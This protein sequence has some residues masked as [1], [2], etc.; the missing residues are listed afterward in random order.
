[1]EE[2][3]GEWVRRKITQKDEGETPAQKT[4]AR[5]K[6]TETMDSRPRINKE[7]VEPLPTARSTERKSPQDKQVETVRR[8]PQAERPEQT[9]GRADAPAQFAKKEE[10]SQRNSRPLQTPAA[11]SGGNVAGKQPQKDF[12]SKNFQGPR[13][14]AKPTKG[15]PKKKGRKSEFRQEVLPEMIKIEEKVSVRDLAAKLLK[16]PADLVKKLM[17]LGMNVSLNN[18][19]DYA[20]AELIALDYNVRVEKEKSLEE[21]ILDTIPDD[22]K[23]MLPRPPVVTVMG[24]VDHGKTSL[25]D[26]IRQ[27]NVVAKEAGGITQH[28]GAYQVTFRNEKITF[29]DT[30]GHEAFTA[31]RARGAKSTDIAILVVAA[32]DG[33]MPQTIEAINHAKAAD[34]P[35]IIAVNKMDKE[36]ANP[37]RVKQQLTEHQLIPEEWGGDSIFVPVSAKTREGIELLLEM[38]L[39]LSEMKELKAESDRPAE[40]LVIEGELDRGRGP[41]ASILV[42][43]GTLRIGDS[44]ICGTTFG[45]VRAMVDDVGKR[46]SKAGPSTPVEVLG[47]AD[48]PM[49]GDP[50]RVV[51]EKVARQVS[52]IRLGEK[53]REEQSKTS[54]VTLDDFFKQIQEGEV[55]ELNLIVKGDVQGSIEALNQSLDRLS[56]DEVKVNVIHTGVGAVTESDVMLASASNAIIIGFN[57]RPDTKARKYAEE[58]NI[59]VRLYR[60]IYETI[61]DIRKAMAGLLDPDHVEKFQGRAEV[62]ATFKVPKAG[63]IAGCYVIDGKV[64]RNA[65]LR[66]LRDGVILHEGKLASLKRFKDDV[67]EVLNNFEC[68]IGIE[69]FN[70]IK[71]GDII[72][73]YTIEDVPREL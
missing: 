1:M 59:D 71:E 30:P 61:E 73:T 36:N 13:G 10:G 21:R 37:D 39:L 24:H 63:I 35:I 43:K 60:V 44:I 42:Q 9:R 26:A 51:D 55:K 56:T 68:G 4:A 67:R 3:Q 41:V 58:E 40:G 18:E 32:D 54:K 20:T 33:V 25:L 15:R 62:R 46:I 47:L 31:M 49:A 12:G 45:K 17:L 16:S 29:I 57:V 70:D 64:S 28:I 65:H 50:F 7:K 19:I 53:K 23:N 11:K 5:A 6:E 22:V 38:I 34:V 14:F 52:S 8:P 2:E 66:I 48:V 72:E 27:T 69:G